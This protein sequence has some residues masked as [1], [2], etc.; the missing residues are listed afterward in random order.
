MKRVD[1]VLSE[2]DTILA[3][4]NDKPNNTENDNNLWKDGD[5]LVANIIMC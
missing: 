3:D 1:D 4:N 5:F 2:F